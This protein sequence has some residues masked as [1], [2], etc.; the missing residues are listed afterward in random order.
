LI[1]TRAV[2][3]GINIPRCQGK[4]IINTAN[5]P[6]EFQKYFVKIQEAFQFHRGQENRNVNLGQCVT[7]QVAESSVQ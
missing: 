6:N 7:L 4:D 3:A 2:A 1:I 5:I